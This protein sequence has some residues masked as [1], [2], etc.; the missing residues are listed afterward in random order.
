VYAADWTIDYDKGGS[1]VYLDLGDLPGVNSIESFDHVSG[2]N[3]GIESSKFVLRIDLSVDTYQAM[4]LGMYEYIVY[5]VTYLDAQGD[6]KTGVLE[7][8]IKGVNDQPDPGP[9]IVIRI[10][11]GEGVKRVNLLAGATDNDRHDTLM[12]KNVNFTYESKAAAQI[13]GVEAIQSELRIDMNEFASLGEGEEEELELN[14]DVEDKYGAKV[15]KKATITIVGESDVDNDHRLCSFNKDN[16]F[17]KTFCWDFLAGYEGI[18]VK[19]LNEKGTLRSEALFYQLYEE[20]PN[21]IVTKWNWHAFGNVLFTSSGEQS[22]SPV[23]DSTAADDTLSEPDPSETPVA[24]DAEPPL[25]DPEPAIEANINVAYMKRMFEDR[26]SKYELYHGPIVTAGVR[27][28]L[29]DGRF[30]KRYY[31]GWRFAQS[32]MSYFD[33]LYGKTEGIKGS[34]VE[35]RGQFYVSKILLGLAINYAVEDG[36][37]EG[38]DYIK[39]YVMK[40]ID[41]KSMLSA[42]FD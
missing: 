34:R 3:D 39:L 18:S 40:P 26:N 4:S 1:P 19:G 12:V 17:R 31:G 11:E 32:Q 36:P 29:E 41:L 37:E 2:Q 7:I 20:D 30:A 13:R 35:F 42:V 22:G 9:D 28:P 15:R 5:T 21:D 27:K 38:A 6:D 16:N 10:K 14:Y 23:A 8:R 33:L 25:N 24:A